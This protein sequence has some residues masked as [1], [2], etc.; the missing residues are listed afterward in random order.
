MKNKR[1]ITQ[2]N[3][4]GAGKM[5]QEILVVDI[6]TTGFLQE[7]G[8]IVE[9]GIVKLNLNTG[10]RKLIYDTVVKEQGFKPFH[11]NAWIFHNSDLSYKDITDAKPLDAFTLQQIFDK[12]PAT[13]YNKRFDFDFLMSRGL[14]IEELDCP[15]K[16]CTPICKLPGY[17]GYK[18]PKVQ[19][20]YDHFFENNDYIEKH[21]AGDDAFHESQI[22]WELYKMG[23]FPVPKILCNL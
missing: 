23:K 3:G 12:Y 20:A 16:I 19:E 9:I 4:N 1:I 11:K 15:M 22:V 6:E 13:A 17:Y 2:F 14:V 10:K 7:Q 21:R 5:T 18:W 8:L